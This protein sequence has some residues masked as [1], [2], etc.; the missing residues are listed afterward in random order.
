M[1]LSAA[2][3]ALCPFEIT[4]HNGPQAARQALTLLLDALSCLS[5]GAEEVCVV[6]LV[7]AEMLNNIVEHAYPDPHHPGPIHIACHHAPDGLHIA[8]SDE[9]LPMPDLQAPLGLP[10]EIDRPVCDLPEGGFGWFLIRD[11]AKDLAYRRLAQEN[12][13]DLR[14]PVG[15]PPR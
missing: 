7:V 8:V 9:G 1:R 14:L 2:R 6:R 11:L 4:V 3:S 5:L 13:I 12:R 15:L 10:Q